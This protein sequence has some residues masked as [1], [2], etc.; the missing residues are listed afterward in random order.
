MA[1]TATPAI[2]SSWPAFLGLHEIILYIVIVLLIVAFGGGPALKALFNAILKIF[3]HGGAETIVNVEQ[4][5]VMAGKIPKECESCGL[6]VDPSKCVMHQS[7]HERSLRN[8]AQITKIWAEYSK[9]R[10]ETLAAQT[11]LKDEMI[12]GFN[13]VHTSIADSNRAILGALAGTRIGF[14][15][16]GRGGGG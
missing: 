8:E 10:D 16:P 4:G 3:G 7:E 5:G 14:E 15:K 9:L 6:V 11:K 12:A 2:L 1:A 13:A